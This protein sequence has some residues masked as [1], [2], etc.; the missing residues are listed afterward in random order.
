MPE[1]GKEWEPDYRDFIDAY[2]RDRCRSLED[3]GRFALALPEHPDF[4]GKFKRLLLAVNDV[5]SVDQRATTENEIPRVT[6]STRW[7]FDN[8]PSGHRMDDRCEDW[9]YWFKDHPDLLRGLKAGS[10]R[11]AAPQDA[12]PPSPPDP[13]RFNHDQEL[14]PLTNAD[15]IPS[16]KE[17]DAHEDVKYALSEDNTLTK[18]EAAERAIKNNPLK[19]RDTSVETL[20]RYDRAVRRYDNN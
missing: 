15:R 5:L 3:L 16:S 10:N 6:I 13:E 14:Q 20:L 18:R 12:R 1:F 7:F 2:S 17:Q 11:S 4:Q 19:Y 9:I 8:Y